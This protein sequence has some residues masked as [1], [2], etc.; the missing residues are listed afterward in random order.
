MSLNQ[1]VISFANHM[2]EAC[3][4]DSASIML[5]N[6]SSQRNSLSYLY[7]TGLRPDFLIQYKNNQIFLKDPF[8]S[9]HREDSGFSF[10]PWNFD[11]ADSSAQA[12]DYHHLIGRFAIAPVGASIVTINPGLALI[13]GA[14]CQSGHYRRRDVTIPKVE[15]HVRQLSDMVILNLLSAMTKDEKGLEILE[16]AC[17]D[18]SKPAV[19]SVLTT[20][21]KQISRMVCLGLRNR[22]IAGEMRL[23]EHTVENHL[24]KIYEKFA[25]NNR[26]SLVSKLSGFI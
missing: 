14:H 18:G 12:I 9:D 1:D 16:Q 11:A 25:I 21:E 17:V 19:D 23:S 13:I 4:I 24:R 20:R 22:E 6:R 7:N 3:Q 26:A 10:R 15:H 5:C 2:V 8:L